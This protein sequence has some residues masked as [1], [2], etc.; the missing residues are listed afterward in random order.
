MHNLSHYEINYDVD[1]F[2][3]IKTKKINMD[4]YRGNYVLDWKEI[5]NEYVCVGIGNV[6]HFAS[7]Y[8]FAK[9][10]N[11]GRTSEREE[12]QTMYIEIITRVHE[13]IALGELPKTINDV[14]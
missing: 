14:A 6:P 9:A 1:R 7:Q 11:S 13:M 12:M 3:F 2:S 10:L 8:V 4:D 5:C